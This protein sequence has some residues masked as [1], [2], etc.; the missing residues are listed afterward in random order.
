MKGRAKIE[1]GTLWGLNSDDSLAVWQNDRV[2]DAAAS[3]F[4][5]VNAAFRSQ[6]LL[7]AFLCTWLG[8]WV[9][10]RCG[11]GTGPYDYEGYNDAGS[12]HPHEN[13]IHTK[14]G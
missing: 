11:Q 9:V 3:V 13:I 7:Q 4:V 6:Y 14:T 10:V 5:H 1:P 12:D 2:F 8:R